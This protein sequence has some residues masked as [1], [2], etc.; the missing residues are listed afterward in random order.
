[1]QS[2]HEVACNT[3]ILFIL[4]SLHRK[5]WNWC[6]FFQHSHS[7]Q[8]SSWHIKDPQH[9]LE[10]ISCANLTKRACH[11][12]WVASVSSYESACTLAR[13]AVTLSCTRVRAPRGNGSYPLH[14]LFQTLR[15][16]LAPVTVVWDSQIS[17]VL[18]GFSAL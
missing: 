1:M 2:P 11:C 13:S 4:H 10:T 7:I 14:A 8:M 15:N 5:T 18:W 9:F 6:M 16:W 17:R 3:Y 12:A